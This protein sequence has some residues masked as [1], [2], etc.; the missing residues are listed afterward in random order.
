MITLWIGIALAGPAPEGVDLED[1]DHWESRSRAL[2]E[3][4]Q[5]CWDL[6]G[7]LEVQLALFTPPGLW[8]RA[9]KRTLRAS[10]SFR[11]QIDGGT[12]RSFDYTMTVTDDSDLELDTDDHIFVPVFPLIGEI[13][14]AVVNADEQEP[15]PP[16]EGSVS[17]SV[18]S[19]SGLEITSS[20]SEAMNLLDEI[21]EAIKPSATTSYAQWF[22]EPAGVKLLQDAPINDSPRSPRLTLST[23]FPDGAPHATELDVDFPPRYKADPD[24]PDRASDAPAG[25]GGRRGDPA[26]DRELVPGRRGARVHRRLRAEDHL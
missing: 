15:P 22:D 10:G 20:S 6:S 19:S 17:I 24:H 11:G 12:W 18:G 1:L 5:G 21:M 9:E 26:D 25:Q 2:L 16:G 8:K 13:D 23:F 4:P 3:G 7:T 14:Q